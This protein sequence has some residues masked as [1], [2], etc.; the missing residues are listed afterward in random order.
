MLFVRQDGKNSRMEYV[1]DA[2]S[3]G[4]VINT[5]INFIGLFNGEKTL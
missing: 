4:A 5:Y 1:D 3:M 2:F